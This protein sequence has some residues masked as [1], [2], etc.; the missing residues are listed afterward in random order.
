MFYMYNSQGS[1]LSVKETP[2]SAFLL[3][4]PS[5]P[6]NLSKN[7]GSGQPQQRRMERREPL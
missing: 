3:C 5:N 4:F 2:T 1:G 6:V 7:K